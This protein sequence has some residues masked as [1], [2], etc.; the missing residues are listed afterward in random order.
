MCVY[1]CSDSEED[2]AERCLDEDAQRLVLEELTDVHFTFE[3][4]TVKF[5]LFYIFIFSQNI[6]FFCLK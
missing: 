4:K 2:T 1:V 3:I 6:N 5:L